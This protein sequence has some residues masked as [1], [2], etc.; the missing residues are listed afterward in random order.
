MS[1]S[2]AH[3]HPHHNRNQSFFKEVT[4][5]RKEQKEEGKW[6]YAQWGKK[7]AHS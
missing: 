6:A 3:P 7:A 4:I 1:S 2:D 5:K